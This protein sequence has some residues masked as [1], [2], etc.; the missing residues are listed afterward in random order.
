[1]R[2]RLVALAALLLL[3]ACVETTAPV[4][5]APTIVC[6]V[7]LDANGVPFDVCRQL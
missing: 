7:Y 3:G 5:P 4:V 6:T 1:M 2:I